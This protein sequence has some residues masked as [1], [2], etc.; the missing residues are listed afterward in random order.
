MNRLMTYG[1]GCLLGSLLIV[2]SWAQAQ[3]GPFLINTHTTGSQYDPAVDIAPDGTFIATWHDVDDPFPGEED[4]GIRLQRFSA[5]GQESGASVHVNTWLRW[6]QVRPDIALRQDG[7]HVVVWDSR[8][9]T[10]ILGDTKKYRYVKMSLFDANGGPLLEDVFVAADGVDAQRPGQTFPRVS[11]A[12]GH[13]ATAGQFVVTWAE[14]V[15]FNGGAGFQSD[16]YARRFASDGSPLGAAFRV[17]STTAKDQERPDVLMWDDG[18]FVIAWDSH[19]QDSS[20]RTVMAQVYDAA[21]VPLGP[22][23]AL[24]SDTSGGQCCV[25]L[26]EASAAAILAQ[27]RFFAVWDE[28]D[29]A[30]PTLQRSIQGRVFSGGG[31]GLTPQFRISP[32]SGARHQGYPAI[33]QRNDDDRAVVTWQEY[34][35]DGSDRDIL[36]RIID[37]QGAVVGAPFC[38]SEDPPTGDGFDQEEP[39]MARNGDDVVVVWRSWAEDGDQLGVFG[40]QLSLTHLPGSC[41]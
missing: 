29:D 3:A 7:S 39:A 16:I 26:G 38:V 5:D 35:A 36:G 32:T 9:R 25:R 20:Q 19:A 41:P 8:E 2:P 37:V 27:P 17:N 21:G 33:S 1:L 22:E 4:T 11:A 34:S 24:P 28:E 31:L 10:P 12:R 18:R 6:D 40:R 14:P 13:L 30:S 23:I 15:P